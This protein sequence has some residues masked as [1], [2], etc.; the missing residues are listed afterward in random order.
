MKERLDRLQRRLEAIRRQHGA[1]VG[2]VA[3]D[4]AGGYTLYNGGDVSHHDTI[5]AARTAFLECSPAPGH[6]PPLIII[7]L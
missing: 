4:E 2:I 1:G 3:P 6:E 5:E 7:D